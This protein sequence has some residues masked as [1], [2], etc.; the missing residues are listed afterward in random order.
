VIL[1]K[2]P[3]MICLVKGDGLLLALLSTTF[4]FTSAC[5]SVA[6][7][8]QTNSAGVYE[9]FAKEFGWLTSF[10]HGMAILHEIASAT[11]KEK[12][13][14]VDAFRGE[15]VAFRGVTAPPGSTNDL[16]GDGGFYLR[17]VNPQGKDLRPKNVKWAEVMICGK[18]LQV[19]PENKIIVIEVDEKDLKVLQ[20][21]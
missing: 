4:V 9:A 11:A 7:T 15:K 13:F 10:N 21:G 8:S 20:T 18:I 2:F 12:K 14:D 3:V 1:E 17:V 5:C 6:Q 19:L 16:I